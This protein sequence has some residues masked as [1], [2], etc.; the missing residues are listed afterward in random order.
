[1]SVTWIEP[2]QPSVSL[3]AAT[4]GSTPQ[5]PRVFVAFDEAG[6]ASMAEV[7][8]HRVTGT[9]WG[10]ILTSAWLTVT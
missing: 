2:A 7:L 5:P 4:R 10:S 1:M 8:I 3:A 6:C 9:V